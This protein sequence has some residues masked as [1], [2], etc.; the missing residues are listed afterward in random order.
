MKKRLIPF[1]LLC[2]WLTGIE[3]KP[4]NAGAPV[5]HI[6][7][8]LI[9]DNSGSMNANDPEGLR[10][11][12]IRLMVSL[13]DVGDSFGLV[14]FST[15]AFSPTS[16][17]ITIRSQAEKSRI[18]AD[19]NDW[20]ADG[21]TDVKSA[22]E[23]AKSILTSLEQNGHRRVVIL[24]T[25]GKPEIQN[26]YVQYESETL[27]LARSLNVPFLAI[28]LTGAAQTPFL[29]QLASATHGRVFPAESS[30]DLLNAYLQVLG[31]IKDRTVIANG[32]FQTDHS[33]TIAP[34][35]APYVNLVSFVLV[36]P[37]NANIRLIGPDRR[38]IINSASNLVFSETGDPKFSIFSLANPVGGEY[39]FHLQGGGD[40]QAWTILYSRLR[41]DVIRPGSFHPLGRGMPIVV[42][43]LEEQ[44]PGHFTRIIGD[45]DFTARIRLPDG[46]LVSLDRFYDDGSHGDEIPGDGNYT[47]IYPGADMKGRYVISIQ[48][49]KG[50]I[51]V[52][53]ETQVNVEPFP[54][55]IMDA[56]TDK[57]NVHERMLRI[58]VHLQGGNPP[59]FDQ[60]NVIA[61]LISPSGSETEITLSGNSVFTGEFQPL[62]DGEYRVQFKTREAM[63]HG[64]PYQTSLERSF[65][66]RRISFVDVSAG[67]GKVPATCFSKPQ[68]IL[69][70]LTI[71]ASRDTGLRFSAPQGWQVSPVMVN[72]K[73]GQ[74]EI[75]I[76]LS[77][78]SD[79][80]WGQFPSV[81]LGIEG[82]GPL[83]VLS[84]ESIKVEYEYPG[85]WTRC[86][87]PLRWGGGAVLLL[88]AGMGALYR[89]HKAA[90]PE[91]VRGTLRHWP[92]GKDP[93]QAQE[94]DLTALRKPMLLIG[95]G[96]TCDVSPSLTDLAGEHARLV[97]GRSEEDI[98]VYLEPIGSVHQGYGVQATRFVLQHGE[99]F[100]MGQH[101]FQYLS[102][103]GA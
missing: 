92:I 65:L 70:S 23:Q 3:A 25:D 2:V 54:G 97:A 48:G 19:L 80:L 42:N 102:D 15:D 22:L 103:H 98:V 37:Q 100:R 82:N 7:V 93:I 36:K 31:Q 34:S 74:H 46:N 55:L 47:R 12:G 50:G 9:L 99:I 57:V 68:E 83:E 6:A 18:L 89:L 29:G 1:L 16:G 14:M 27:E 66:V 49:W 35:L 10:F 94:I 71:T 32:K 21:Y 45:A 87:V 40:A 43:L 53:L 64:V 96:A 86:R 30:S 51:P 5:E 79:T 73:Q 39:V 13:L 33:Q 88:L 38:E 101:E 72:V 59:V 41:M 63:Y 85:L 17:L 28:A 77:A 91:L 58:Q 62:E 11:T 60:G 26:P 76:R 75:P 67:V 81:D 8:L 78:A 84:E 44:A 69:I 95:S 24:L 52:Q 90:Q 20:E 61:R 56:P 4:A